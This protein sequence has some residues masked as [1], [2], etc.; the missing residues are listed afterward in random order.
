MAKGN[1]YHCLCCG[2]EY[3]Y[4]PKCDITKPTYDAENFCSK[5]HSEIFAILSKHGCDLAS[6]EDTLKALEKFDLTNLSE[7]I[8]K[9]I[10]Q[11]FEEVEL[12]EVETTTQE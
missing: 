3:V 1:T 5:A 6:A 8:N 2:E 11:L 4:C 12:K 9:H 10:D 7:S